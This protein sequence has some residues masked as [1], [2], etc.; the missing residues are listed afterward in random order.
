MKEKIIPVVSVLIGIIAFVTT[1]QYISTQKEMLEKQRQELLESARKTRVVVASHDIP[2]GTR[3]KASDIGSLPVPASYITDDIVMPEDAA[4]ILGKKT[5]QP[6]VAEKPISWYFI[7]G[8]RSAMDGL[9]DTI[10]PGMRAISLPISGAA[11]VS[12]MVRPNDRV[13]VI[14]TFSMPYK[15]VTGELSSELMETVTLTILQDVSVIATGQKMAKQ[16]SSS[17]RSKSSSHSYNTV[18]VEVTPREAE[19]LV[20]LQQTTRGSMTLS[21]RHPEDV[22]YEKELPTVN[23][24]HLQ[25]ELPKLN[26]YRQKTIRRKT[27]R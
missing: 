23:F 2:S 1:S 27:I 14:G 21:L 10:T 3:I 26:E 19:L 4:A 13:D 7:E 15:G 22:N 12:G 20:F 17:D 16:T 5:T 11:T 24:E 25:N 6:I 8:G 18:T 9:A